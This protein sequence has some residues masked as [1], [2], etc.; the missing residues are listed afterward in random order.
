[1]ERQAIHVPLPNAR[2][3]RTRAGEGGSSGQSVYAP[4]LQVRHEQAHADK[5]T[6]VTARL[7]CPR[8]IPVKA[9][10]R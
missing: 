5:K 10:L 1:M 6:P 4:W 8:D 3:A 2:H 7:V 9:I